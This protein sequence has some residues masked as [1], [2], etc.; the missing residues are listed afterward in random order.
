MKSIDYPNV[1]LKYVLPPLCAPD[2]NMG[3]GVT[4]RILRLGIGW[5]NIS[6][7]S[8]RALY[9]MSSLTNELYWTKIHYVK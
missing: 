2:V 9:V 3:D 5:D 7:K 8:G 6:S 4:D 1:P